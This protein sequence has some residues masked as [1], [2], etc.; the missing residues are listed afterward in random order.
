MVVTLLWE[1][2]HD[3]VNIVKQHAINYESLS[4]LVF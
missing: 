2:E 3:I 4:A 1:G